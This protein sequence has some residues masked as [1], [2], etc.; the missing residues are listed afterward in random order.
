MPYYLLDNPPA[1]RQFYTTRNASPT[2]AVGVHTSEGATGPGSARALSAY[3]AR[4]SD[5]GSYAVIVDSEETV[6][7]VPP[8]FTTFSVASSGFNSRTWHI[9]LAGRS[10]D[11][12]PDDPNTQAMI[13]R[14]GAAI[15][16]LWQS[17]GIDVNDAAQWVGTDALNR[18]GLFCHGDVQ[19]A[20]RSDAWSRHPDRNALDQ[21]LV[22]AIR[23]TSPVHGT[24]TTKVTEMFH[25][26]NTDGRDE[27]IALTD[28][29][30]VVSC[31]SGKPGG[32]IGPWQ[33]VKSGIAGSNL[34]AEYAADGRLC[35]TLATMGQ[36]WG[37]WQTAPSA[38]PWCDWFLV[39][40][41]RRFLSK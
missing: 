40:D 27:Y 12:S 25:M 22:N 21:Q 23:I 7:L 2:W 39:N 31:W 1:S 8:D 36:L 30:Q 33:E 4:R 11:L 24:I 35:V 10:A 18:V 5:P 29:G 38:G 15:R 32:P 3:I 28:G 26:K 34:V 6:Y 16:E 9:C 13:V 37:S 14:A 19:P 17:L 41:L 20:D